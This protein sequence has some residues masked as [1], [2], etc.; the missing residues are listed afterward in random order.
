MNR[1]DGRKILFV[2]TVARHFYYFHLPVFK[3]LATSGWQVDAAARVDLNAA[4]PYTNHVFDLPF[5]RSPY[6]AQNLCAYRQLRKICKEGRYDIVH[7]HTPVGGL[8]GRLAARGTGARVIYTA[9]GF[10]FCKGAPLR[11]WLMYLPAEWLMAWLTDTLITI[12]EEDF[13]FAKR[14]LH[15][16]HTAHVHG[17]GCDINAFGGMA[18]TEEQ[19][20]VL[21]LI[22][23]AELNANKNQG[24]LIR[25]MPDILQAYPN[26]RL[27]LAGSDNLSGFYQSLCNKLDLQ[28]HVD[29]LGERA[30]IAALLR[31]CDVYVASS[32]R[33]GLPMNV[34][35]AMASGLP[36]VAVQNRGHAA[37]V[38]HEA[39]GLLVPKND[40]AAFAAAVARLL[41]DASMRNAFGQAGRERAKLFSRG[42]VLRELREIY[43]SSSFSEEK[44]AKRLFPASRGHF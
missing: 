13:D 15:A 17:V 28:S 43:D 1:H 10:H 41:G 38:E 23:V 37:L 31:T 40:S 32:L 39:T 36:V 26:V 2:A 7:C 5:A 42:R 27:L 33:E 9:H 3:M 20:D 44:E 21:R 25:S 29:F 34:L 16:K 30:D 14:H 4:L 6:N 24:F 8:L 12:N 11:N 22:Y 18:R 19:K 35:E